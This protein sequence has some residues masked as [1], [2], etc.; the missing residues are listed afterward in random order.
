MRR[1]RGWLA[2]AALL[3]GVLVGPAGAQAPPTLTVSPESV[4]PGATV[5]VTASG[6]ADVPLVG[7]QV[8]GTDGETVELTLTLTLTHDGDGTSSG[9]VVA[10]RGDLFFFLL[11]G[12]DGA[13]AEARAE[14][15]DPFLFA[16]PSNDLPLT[17]TGTDCPPNAT[18][19]VS[20]TTGGQTYEVPDL[21]VDAFGD[22]V[23][24]V[25]LDLP[26]AP[27]GPTTVE[28]T[29][30]DVVYAPLELTPPLVEAVPP[31]TGVTTTTAAGSPGTAAPASPIAG[32]ARFTG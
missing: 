7:Y 32:N 23:L 14:V 22:F 16:L 30:G 25:L 31:I 28:A 5:T 8:Q 29:C 12:C 27:A 10:G 11:D 18:P 13:Q 2:G 9:E 4:L 17:I 20:V 19:V 15:E 6:C 26:V 21:T 3:R 1:W 24:D